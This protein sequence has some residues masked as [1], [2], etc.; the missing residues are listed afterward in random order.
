MGFK[1][2]TIGI[3]GGKGGMGRWF[4]AFF[5]EA[6]F[7]VRI[8]DLDTALTN[9]ALVTSSD[10]V[11]FATPIS[12]TTELVRKLGPLFTEKQLLADLTSLK[13]EVMDAM[14]AFS[15]SAVL[16]IHPLFGPHTSGI[17]GQNM[18]LVPGRGEEWFEAFGELFREKGC[19]VHR[20]EAEAHDE[21]MCFVQGITHFFTISLGAYMLKKGLAPETAHAVATPTSRLNV[22]FVGRLFSFDLELY[23]DL[24]AKNSHMEGAV[25]DFLSVLGESAEVLLH[26]S[27]PER[28]KW[29][30]N[31]RE[32]LGAFP[33]KG[34]EESNRVLDFLVR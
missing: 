31:I 29:L 33:E 14:L 7:S 9:E 24:I 16:G 13:Q 20:M 28:G 5:R 32:F 23:A 27:Q 2:K 18:I 1:T 8:S 19:T 6:G 15:S 22:D 34:L 25:R 11:I 30:R 3:I 10:V 17:S 12:V 4:D 21:H 26:G